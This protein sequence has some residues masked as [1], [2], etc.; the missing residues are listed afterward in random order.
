MPGGLTTAVP[1]TGSAG[2]FAAVTSMAVSVTAD[3]VTTNQTTQLIIAGIGAFGSIC[4]VLVARYAPTELARH[5]DR[6]R[7]D[8]SQSDDEDEHASYVRLL[9]EDNR[10]QR[11]QI[12]SDRADLAVLRQE[13][14]QLRDLI[15]ELQGSR[16]DH[17]GS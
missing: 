14:R 8:H 5:R 6:V 16:K 13:Q 17:N 9:E 3:A 11:E 7:R 15:D 1:V 12:E 10:A 4:A 2:P